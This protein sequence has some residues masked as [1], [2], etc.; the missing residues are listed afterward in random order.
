M[1]IKELTKSKMI[2]D[3]PAISLNSESSGNVVARFQGKDIYES[4]GFFGGNWYLSGNTVVNCS[5]LDDDDYNK[6]WYDMQ[7]MY[8]K[9]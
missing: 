9:R 6:G 5:P 8:L 7:R 3:V 4:E 1:R 2:L